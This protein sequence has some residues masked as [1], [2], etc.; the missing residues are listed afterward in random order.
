MDT[1]RDFGR[2]RRLLRKRQFDDVLRNA[3]VRTTRGAL[4]LAARDSGLETARLGLI[5][6]KRMLPLAVDRNRAKRV[7]RETFR[8]ARGLPPMDIVVRLRAPARISARD[9]E[10][11][12]GALAEIV[13]R[14]GGAREDS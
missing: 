7:I 8:Q 13:E 2:A 4:W 10:R 5:V 6:G 12:F 3:A 9:A 11:L 14:R 1:G